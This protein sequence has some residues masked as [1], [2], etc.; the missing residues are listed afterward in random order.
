MPTLATHVAEVSSLSARLREKNASERQSL[1]ETDANSERFAIATYSEQTEPA[2]Q[3]MGLN[4]SG[5]VNGFSD[6]ETM[7][8]ELV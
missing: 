4:S 8:S 5:V 6:E 2:R 7:H 1:C 3:A